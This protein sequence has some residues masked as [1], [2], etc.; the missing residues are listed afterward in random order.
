MSFELFI[1]NSSLCINSRWP[2]VS[3]NYCSINAQY[4]YPQFPLKSD[5]ARNIWLSHKSTCHNETDFRKSP[6]T[7]LT[8]NIV[9][10]CC[11][12][13]RQLTD[14]YLLIV[15][16]TLFKR[17]P[18]SSAGHSFTILD[19]V[20]VCL[21][22]SSLEE[23]RVNGDSFSLST[24]EVAEVS[25]LYLKNSALSKSIRLIMTITS[26]TKSNRH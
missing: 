19:L 5:K 15:P 21:R 12:F 9:T 10:A 13:T 24:G 25:A 16:V 2:I 11:E 17:L 3:F 7:H 20:L 18:P 26:D 22:S 8:E 14:N 23:G 1:C 4:H 6:A